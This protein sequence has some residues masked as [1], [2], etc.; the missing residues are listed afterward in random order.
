M[1]RPDFRL[2]LCLLGAGACWPWSASAGID[3]LDTETAL[4][5][6]RPIRELVSQDGMPADE[7]AAAQAENVSDPEAQN[8]HGIQARNLAP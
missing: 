1:K 8:F 6:W 3:C 2:A 4:E 5:Y 7:L